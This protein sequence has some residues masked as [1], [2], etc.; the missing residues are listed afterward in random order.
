[1]RAHRPENALQE[2]LENTSL[3]DLNYSVKLPKFG[4]RSERE[5][6]VGAGFGFSLRRR[7]SE[8]VLVEE[9]CVADSEPCGSVSPLRSPQHLALPSGIAPPAT[10]TKA[11]LCGLAAAQ[12]QATD[13]LDLVATDVKAPGRTLM[14]VAGPAA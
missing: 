3:C 1:V 13:I 14:C 9:I 8:N 6:K 12:S 2:T 7:L 10:P 11:R 5:L 4:I